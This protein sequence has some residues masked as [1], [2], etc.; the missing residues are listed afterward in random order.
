MVFTS[1]ICST[2]SPKYILTQLLAASVLIQVWLF[3]VF[4]LVMWEKKYCGIN[5]H[6]CCVRCLAGILEKIDHFQYLNI[7]SVWIGPVYRSP[8]RDFGYDVEDFRAIDPLFGTMDDFEEL[9]AEMHSKGVYFHGSKSDGGSSHVWGVEALN[10]WCMSLT[11]TNLSLLPPGLN[12]I[13]D[14]IPNHTSDRHHWFNLSRTRDP[15]Y[16]DYYVWTDCNATAPKPNNWVST[17]IVLLYL[18]SVLVLVCI[19]TEP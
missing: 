7:K 11:H 16:K 19:F 15:H 5:I 2:V 6:H 18:E 10:R 13:M 8:M 14:F 17:L 12:L 4:E 1:M 9:L 3:F